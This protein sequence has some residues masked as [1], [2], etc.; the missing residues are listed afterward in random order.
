MKRIFLFLMIYSVCWSTLSASENYRE[1]MDYLLH[2]VTGHR[3]GIVVQDEDGIKLNVHTS[4][5][6]KAPNGKYYYRWWNSEVRFTYP[7]GNIYEPVDDDFCNPKDRKPLDIGYRFDDDKMYIYNFKTEEESVAY[8]FT[9]QVGEKFTTPDGVCWEV[10]NR[11]TEVFE[12]LFE[13]MTDYKNEHVVLSVQSSDGTMKDEWIQYIGS[14][15]YPI[16]N[17]GRTDIKQSH[18]A[19]FNFTSEDEKLVYFN[20]AEDPL[21]GQYLDV[22]PTP[23]ANLPEYGVKDYT[24]TAG[25]DSLN[26]TVSCYTFATRRYCYTYRNGSTFDIRSF[27]LGPYRDGGDGGSASLGFEFPGAPLFDNYSII[28]DGVT[29]TTKIDTQQVPN[30][31]HTTFDLSG[32]RVINP[33]RGLYI[34]GGKRVLIE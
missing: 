28:Y 27:E 13:G 21:F 34:Q 3:Q 10:V 23:D 31:T 29:L 22:E 20:F 4:C 32:R 19:F 24:V 18:T 11:R 12:S 30:R 17:W 25:E 16:Q 1:D 2:K 8:D 7:N 6:F 5:Y 15:N 14:L 26:I 9:L 33:K